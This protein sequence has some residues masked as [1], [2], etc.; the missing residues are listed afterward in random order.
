M[1][2][3]KGMLGIK[4]FISNKPVHFGVKLWELCESVTGCCYKFGVY[5]NK[6]KSETNPV[7]S[8]SVAAVLNL[9]KGLEHKNC[10]IYF[11]NYYTSV[12][13]LLAL[14]ENGFGACRTIR[15]NCR[16]CPI[17]V[18]AADV[19]HKL[20]GTFTWRS[21]GSLLALMW[22]DRK[23]ILFLSS[24][25]Q[26]SEGQAVKRKVKCDNRNEE[27]EFPC[28]TLVND[29]NKFMGGVDYNDQMTHLR[30]EKQQKIW[31]IRLIIK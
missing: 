18:L 9:V 25:H 11:D 28:L 22:K 1:V 21:N 4:Q 2:S 3:F 10:D 29:Y 7:L 27:I 12:P 5:V 31:Y 8:K 16:Y 24:I 30:K 15:A 20:R 13:L 14:A 6:S 17:D 26:P 19:K 23:S